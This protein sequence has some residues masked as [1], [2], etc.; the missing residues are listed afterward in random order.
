MNALYIDIA[1]VAIVLLFALIGLWRGFFRTLLSFFGFI[2][3][4]IISAYLAS[5]LVRTLLPVPFVAGIFG[6]EGSLTGKIAEMITKISPEIFGAS[7]NDLPA[8]LASTLTET[9]KLPAVVA[10]II[11]SAVSGIHFTDSTLTLATIIA[12]AISG[13]IL[14][15]IIAAVLFLILRIIIHFLKK[16][17]KTLTKNKHINNLDRLFGF[18]LGGVKGFAMV[19][20]VFGVMT[21]FIGAE[22]MHDFNDSLKGTTI[23]R[24]ISDA[25]F[26]WVGD[27]IDLEKIL[28]DTFK[29][30]F[31]ITAPMNDRSKSIYDTLN[32]VPFDSHPVSDFE[33]VDSGLGAAYSADMSLHQNVLTVI[34]LGLINGKSDEELNAMQAAAEQIR[35]KYAELF[36]LRAE[37][38]DADEAD[39]PAIATNM[40]NI[41]GE[42]SG[43]YNSG[44]G[45]ILSSLS[46]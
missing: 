9:L 6:G 31:Q 21:F 37:Y 38:D 14:W 20:L 45:S 28:K 42:I 5:F 18:L 2:V 32:E 26:K 16:F 34:N 33:A 4:I 17:F 40:F 39:L 44:F 12:A 30:K 19:L 3:S 24:P 27:T 13:A 35:S 10:Q 43:L 25:V 41:L 1:L 15:L 22:F 11:A 36:E 7:P 8:T 29:G 23:A 46:G